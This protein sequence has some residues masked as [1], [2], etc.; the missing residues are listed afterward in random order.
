VARIKFLIL[1]L[2]DIPFEE[3]VYPCYPQKWP[4]F[5]YPPSSDSWENK[6]KQRDSDDQRRWRVKYH[7]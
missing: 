6:L 4:D 1:S 7:L 5:T 2:N 3:F